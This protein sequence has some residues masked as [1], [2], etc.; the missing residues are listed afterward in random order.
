MATQSV[1]RIRQRE[2]FLALHRPAGRANAGP[3]QVSWVPGPET[4]AHV[5]YA[6]GR[7]CGGAVQRNRLRRRLREAVR[8]SGPPPGN[9]L[10]VASAG[11]GGLGF[12]ELA[13]AVGS[14]MTTAAAK[15]SAQ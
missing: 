13:S 10:V 14:A 1:G 9:Y 4:S 6:V 3:L 5:G 12:S 2:V 15:G 8:A 11:A 7:R